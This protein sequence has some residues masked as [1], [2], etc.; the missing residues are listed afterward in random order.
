MK[1]K[2][3]LIFKRGLTN[4]HIDQLRYDGYSGG[5]DPQHG[6]EIIG[7]IERTYICEFVYALGGWFVIRRRWYHWLHYWAFGWMYRPK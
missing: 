3:V 4:I 6:T 1:S 7:F 5:K 2:A